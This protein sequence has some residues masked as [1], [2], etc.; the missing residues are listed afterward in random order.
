MTVDRPSMKI[1]VGV[2]G[3]PSGRTAL[4]WAIDA[5]AARRLQVQAVYT[6]HVP[7]AAYGAPGFI[8][9]DAEQVRKEA[10]HM[11]EAELAEIGADPAVPVQI[12]VVEG[13]APAVLRGLAE[14]PQVSLVVVGTRGHGTAAGMML[15]SVSHAL[16]HDS[17]KPLVIVPDTNG[18]DTTHRRIGHVVVGVDGSPGAAAA[19]EWA[20][21]EARARSAR[22]ELVAAWSWTS[23]TL[24]P[25]FSSNVNFETAVRQVCHEN[26]E[27]V[28]SQAVDGVDLTGL[29][30]VRTVREGP[31][32]E[33]LLEAAATSDLLVVGSRGLGKTKELFLGSVS[34]TLAHH[35]KVPTVIVP[36][37]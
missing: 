21:A 28:L 4:A 9:L 36:H 33:V 11:I 6:W 32:A 25:N 10:E 18:S 35:V 20:A 34:H 30:V 12:D 19:V 22:L 17:P 14:D 15:G 7:A 2:D 13:Q 29:E 8:P 24:P 26:A 1:L 37:R 27:N 23:Q 5:A 31:P 16:S 3:S